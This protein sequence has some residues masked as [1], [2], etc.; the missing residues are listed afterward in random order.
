MITLGSKIFLE[1]FDSLDP[2]KII[3]IKK[4]VG[5]YVKSLENNGEV[6]NN[7]KLKLE[8]LN[9]EFK[10]IGSLEEKTVEANDLNLFYSLNSVLTKLRT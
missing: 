7:L 2:A 5:N 4:I 1:G 8:V 10:I 3:V 6:V 9:D